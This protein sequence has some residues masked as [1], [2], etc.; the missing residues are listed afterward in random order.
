VIGPSRGL[1]GRC[2]MTV[3]QRGKDLGVTYWSLIGFSEL[4]GFK[5][6]WP[7]AFWIHYFQTADS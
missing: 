4:P 1:K 5:S 6:P 3:A 7:D 2:L